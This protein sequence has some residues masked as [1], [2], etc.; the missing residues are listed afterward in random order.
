MRYFAVIVD[1]T[2]I[3]VLLQLEIEYLH[4]Q[5][6]E[7]SGIH[8]FQIFSCDNDFH[9]GW[10]GNSYKTILNA[11]MKSLVSVTVSCQPTEIFE[12]ELVLESNY[13]LYYWKCSMHVLVIGIE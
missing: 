8:Y 13:M 7:F 11:S 12:I 9:V 4:D 1:P 6:W 2:L 10:F 3:D 5:F